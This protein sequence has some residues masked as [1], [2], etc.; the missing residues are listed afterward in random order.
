MLAGGTEHPRHQI[1]LIRRLTVWLSVAV[2]WQT[3]FQE[4]QLIWS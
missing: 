3:I 4:V 2:I 1:E